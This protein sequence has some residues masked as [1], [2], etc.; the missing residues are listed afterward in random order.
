M[1]EILLIVVMGWSV[2][3]VLVN[4]YEM[5]WSLVYMLRYP[6]DLLLAIASMAAG[7]LVC[8]MLGLI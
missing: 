6:V 1:L 8:R 4:L 2:L 3:G 5:G 7:I